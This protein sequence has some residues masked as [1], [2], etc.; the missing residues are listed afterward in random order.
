MHLCNEL[1]PVV[2]QIWK[3]KINS[4]LCTDFDASGHILTKVFALT[5]D[6]LLLLLLR[7][8]GIHSITIFCN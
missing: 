2:V 4:N 3:Y 5:I 6:Y 1:N 7:I 8:C